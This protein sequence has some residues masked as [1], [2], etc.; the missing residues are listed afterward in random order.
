[1][2]FGGPYSNLQAT[3]AVLLESVKYVANPVCTGDR[4]A[5]CAR[6]T[7]TVAVLRSAN[8][9]VID[10]NCEVQLAARANSCGCG[11]TS[12]S[13][14]YALSIDWFGFASS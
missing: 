12:D 13:V 5:Y 8:F 10:G 2:I 3:Q 6:P 7:E 1:M 11:F 9:E 4:V 14:C